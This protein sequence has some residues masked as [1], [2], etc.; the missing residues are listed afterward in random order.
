[1]EQKFQ[2]ELCFRESSMQAAIDR[3]THTYGLL[4]NLTAEQEQ[5]AREKVSNFLAS[6]HTDDENK[7]AVEGLRYLRVCSVSAVEVDQ[8]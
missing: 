8:K 5:V 3:V 7:L 2:F 6:A 1:M 4:V